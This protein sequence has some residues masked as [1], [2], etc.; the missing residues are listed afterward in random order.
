MIQ[1][2]AQFWFFRKGSGKS[3]FTTFCVWFLVR[4]FLILYSTSWLSDCLYFLK[5]WVMCVS[6][7]YFPGCD[8]INFEKKNFERKKLFKW[9]KNHFSSFLKGFHLPKISLRLENVPEI[10][11]CFY[12]YAFMLHIY[13]K[14]I[15]CILQKFRGLSKGNSQKQPP[16]VF[17]KK[18]CS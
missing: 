7:V 2:C 15:I 10:V 16:E 18:R 9:T 17:C 14:F 5:Y 11:L 1:R 4:I 6:I 12:C 8:I 3:F 13:F